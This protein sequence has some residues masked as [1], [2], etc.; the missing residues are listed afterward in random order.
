MKHNYSLVALFATVLLSSCQGQE[1]I[2]QV[3]EA[4]LMYK[5]EALE[6]NFA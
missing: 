1:D 2:P 3:N 6:K 4:N 5:H